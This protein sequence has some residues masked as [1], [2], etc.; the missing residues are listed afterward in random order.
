MMGQPPPVFYGDRTKA[1]EFLDQVEG[2]LRLNR[3]VT[4]FNLPI[5]KVAFTLS[6]IQGAETAG[7]K[8][9]MGRLL[10]ALDPVADNVPALWDQ[11]LLEFRTQYQDTQRHNRAR[12]Q[13]ETH[14]MRFPDID[15]YISSFEELARQAGYTQGDD[16]T[17]HYFVKGLAPSVLIDV[18]KPP[19]PQT[20]AEIKQRAIDSTRSRMLIDDILG[21]RRVPGRG[22]PPPPR[23]F[24]RPPGQNRPFFSQNNTPPRGPP[25]APQY[26]STNAPRWMNNTPV[27]MDLS[28]ARAPTWRGNRNNAFGRATQAQR[29]LTC[30]QCGK[31][32]HFARNCP[33]RRFGANAAYTPSYEDY[34]YS[35]GFDSNPANYDPGEM[36]P[37]EPQSTIA[38]VKAELE[39]MSTEDKARLAQE[40]GGSGSDFQEA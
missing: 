11:F 5:K 14:R 22:P 30:F 31:E 21:K 15:Q 28:R 10:D 4:G 24:G 12:A 37:E 35:S 36:L 23:P 18:Y 34:D 39:A 20:Y 8:R 32:G 13:I 7:W 38:R 17:T 25:T 26:N 40:M 27:P 9:D 16:A 2:Y 19:V 29:P 33:Q 1:D 3:D 6:H